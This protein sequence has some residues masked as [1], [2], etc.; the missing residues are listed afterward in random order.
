ML[1]NTL[2]ILTVLLSSPPINKRGMGKYSTLILDLSLP[3]FS[4]ASLTSCILKLFFLLYVYVFTHM[5]SAC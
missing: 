2:H 5:M 1:L 4:S 3:P